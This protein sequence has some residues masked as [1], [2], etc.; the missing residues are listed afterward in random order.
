MCRIV[1]VTEILKLTGCGGG[2][3]KAMGVGRAAAGGKREK[4]GKEQLG[5]DTTEKEEGEA[6]GEGGE[7]ERRLGGYHHS[8]VLYV[9]H[10]L[11]TVQYDTTCTVHMRKFSSRAQ[12]R[13]KCSVYME[14]NN[15]INIYN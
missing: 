6:R 8:L 12:G 9:F 13:C 4:K 15:R 10:K 14:I 11:C 2:S 3:C 1:H 7:R 5:Y